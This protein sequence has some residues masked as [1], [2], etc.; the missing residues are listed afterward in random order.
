MNGTDGGGDQGLVA[1]AN[2]DCTLTDA[3][4][5]AA[6]DISEVLDSEGPPAAKRYA[7]DK[8]GWEPLGSGVS[9]IA[10]ASDGDPDVA[11]F[12]VVPRA[13][14]ANYVADPEA[15]VIKVGA[16]KAAQMRTEIQQWRK[17]SGA[18]SS[19][20]PWE[21]LAPYVAPVADFDR[22]AYRWLTMPRGDTEA[23]DAGDLAVL[24]E[25][26]GKAGFTPSDLTA[27]NI[28]LFDDGAKVIDIGME[29]VY[30]GYTPQQRWDV[31]RDRLRQA[32][33]REVTGGVYRSFQRQYDFLPPERLPGEPYTMRESFLRYT[34]GGELLGMEL[35]G[36]KLSAAE[37]DEPAVQET[38]DDVIQ[39]DDFLSGAQARIRRT[40]GG[41]VPTLFMSTTTGQG[42]PLVDVEVFLAAYYDRY[43][44]HFARL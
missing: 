17:I 8:Y 29:F 3:G 6:V 41:M 12:Q 22:G 28:A 24:Q 4:V 21:N 20:E 25:A 37:T 16:P 38:F 5:T 33:C 14:V 44:T 43:D 18:E 39:M 27:S 23:A 31:H 19:E 34:Q 7:L 40:G 10:F 30:T 35:Y 2:A 42:P 13:D 26:V 32:G 1:A 36:T 9:R 15:C 11:A